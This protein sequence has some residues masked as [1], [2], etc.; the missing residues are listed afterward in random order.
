MLPIGFLV[1]LGGYGLTS[2]GYCILR[3]WNIPFG[4]WFNPVH[5]WEWTADNAASPPPIPPTQVN[6]SSSVKTVSPPAAA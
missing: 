6:P 5:P 1:T 3:G 4:Q 2:W